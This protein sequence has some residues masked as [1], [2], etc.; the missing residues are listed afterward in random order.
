MVE[1]MDKKL[2]PANAIHKQST[3]LTVKEKVGGIHIT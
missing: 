2:C 3:K 1:E